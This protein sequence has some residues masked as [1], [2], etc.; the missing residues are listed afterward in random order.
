MLTFLR[1]TSSAVKSLKMIIISIED[2]E[3][4][5]VAGFTNLFK[6][7]VNERHAFRQ[8]NTLFSYKNHLTEKQP[9]RYI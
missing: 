2:S 9:E 6:N 7:S 3:K 5:S 1:K 8:T 4:L